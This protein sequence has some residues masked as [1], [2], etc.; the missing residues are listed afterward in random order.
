MPVAVVLM[1]V[2]VSWLLLGET[3]HRDI[4][5]PHSRVR[6]TC[7]QCGREVT[8]GWR[9]CPWCGYRSEGRQTSTPT[10]RTGS[11]D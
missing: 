9:L 7:P 3:P 11:C 1:V 8:E 10:E 5:N 2:G 6:L 4:G